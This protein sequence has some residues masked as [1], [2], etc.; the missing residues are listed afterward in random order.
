MQ[1]IPVQPDVQSAHLGCTNTAVQGLDIDLLLS[2][3]SC[4]WFDNAGFSA[5]AINAIT[6]GLFV[7]FCLFYYPK[8]C[9]KYYSTCHNF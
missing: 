8:A 5:V 4:D 9:M 1:D 6:F 2:H 3:G 7:L